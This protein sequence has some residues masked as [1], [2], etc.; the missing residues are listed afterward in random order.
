M[1]ELQERKGTRIRINDDVELYI[2]ENDES[3]EIRHKDI[4]IPLNNEDACKVYSSLESCL[5]SN[6]PYI[7][8]YN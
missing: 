5:F 4:V 2:C 1:S 7:E 8:D 6:V 3:V